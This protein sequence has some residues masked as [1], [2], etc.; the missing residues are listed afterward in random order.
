[1]QEQY[2]L[3]EEAPAEDECPWPDIVTTGSLERCLTK[4]NA[5]HNGEQAMVRDWEIEYLMVCPPQSYWVEA[6]PL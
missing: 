3:F 4:Y 1:M 6:M 5:Y 2:G